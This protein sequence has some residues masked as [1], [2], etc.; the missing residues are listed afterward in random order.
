[1]PLFRRRPAA[2]P[3]EPA[4]IPVPTPTID[5]WTLAGTVLATKLGGLDLRELETLLHGIAIGAENGT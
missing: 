1:M 2:P 5:G 3:V 4:P